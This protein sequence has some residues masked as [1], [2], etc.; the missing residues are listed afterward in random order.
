MKRSLTRN[1]KGVDGLPFKLLI[2]LLVVTLSFPAMTSALEYFSYTSNLS[3][4][5]KSANSI[6][7]AGAS[8]YIGGKG[9]IRTV[10]LH[11]PS[12]LLA[13]K[14]GGGVNDAEAYIIEVLWKGEVAATV[15]FERPSFKLITEI[16]N[17]IE[18]QGEA[19]L[20]L[21]CVE[22]TDKSAVLLEVIKC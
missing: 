5:L 8:A 12:S 13:I 10:H 21:T 2:T 16:G 22:I 18:L 1:K 19:T 15:V 11:L 17:R 20:R 6:W 7:E 4:A 14:L 3:L 9:N